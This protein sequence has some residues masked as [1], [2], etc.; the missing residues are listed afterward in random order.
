MPFPK[1]NARIDL[2]L[3]IAQVVIRSTYQSKQSV[4]NWSLANNDDFTA[5]TTASCQVGRQVISKLDNLL[6]ANTRNEKREIA[7]LRQMESITTIFELLC[8]TSKAALPPIPTPALQLIVELCT[9]RVT[10]RISVSE[11]SSDGE[12][13]QSMNAIDQS[14][15]RTLEHVRTQRDGRSGGIF[16]NLLADQWIHDIKEKSRD[17]R[18]SPVSLPLS[19]IWLL[20]LQTTQPGN[21]PDLAQDCTLPSTTARREPGQHRSSDR[22]SEHR[23]DPP[24]KPARTKR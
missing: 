19:H 22:P 3:C 4:P 11:A 10:G 21:P 20:V 6:Q 1:G 5:I 12:C 23:N 17:G 16:W 9:R 13:Q 18:M 14:L 24:S 2:G 15:M 7:V 8:G